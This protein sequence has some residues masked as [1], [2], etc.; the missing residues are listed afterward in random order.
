MEHSKTAP[1]ENIMGTMPV[2]RLLLTMSVP[3][4]ISMLVQ[5][6]YNIV[7]SM[8]VAQI[9]ENALTAVSL[10]FPVQNLM[11]AVATGTG[12]GVNAL[13]SRNLG[14]KKT[15][16]V[17]LA[18]SNSLFLAFCSY[19]L[20]LV[21]GILASR[22]FFLVQTNNAEIVEYGTTYLMICTVFSF[23]QFGQLAFE[24]LLQSTGK[25][26]YTMITQG[27]GAV[28]NI[29]FDP[30]LIFGLLGF[31]KM[32]IAG[33]AAATVFGQI[34]AGILA[35]CFCFWKNH[36]VKI[37]WGG[38]KPNR[39]TIA[40]I[41]S[42]GIPS[43]I[44]SSISSIMTFGMNKILI[45]F[46]PTAT[47]AFGVYFKLQSFIFMPIFGLNNGVVPIIAFNYG[48]GKPKRI[49]Q[50]LK[51]SICYATAIMLIGLA[52][53]MMFPASLLHI[54]NASDYMLEIGIPMLR[55]ISLSFIFGGF[56]IVCITMFQALA[57]GILSLIVSAARQLLVLLPAAYILAQT[58][59]ME[60]VWWAFPIAEIV[61]VVLCVLGF[62]HVYRQDIDKLGKDKDSLY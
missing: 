45:A 25:T 19:A 59:H 4:V 13:L 51:L 34:V 39:K 16:A 27:V 14:E 2:N 58:G 18:A 1:Q 55:T 57:H 48:A 38:I 37:T 33:A 61:S 17:N 42:V 36:E 54:F 3:M 24:R 20:F 62:R 50:T 29:I 10:A 49:M 56:C 26:F 47:A 35:M 11:I 43:I 7:D 46:S 28:L 44:L 53:F 15:A 32:G 52:I 31:P 5:A 30:I 9:S 60:L 6:L 8:F 22:S 41:Y 12:V 40:R 21:L 23:G